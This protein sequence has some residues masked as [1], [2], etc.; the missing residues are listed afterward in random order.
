MET[1]KITDNLIT[2]EG[3]DTYK[4][5]NELEKCIIMALLKLSILP[6][7]IPMESIYKHFGGYTLRGVPD[8][9]TVLPDGT[10]V[11]FEIKRKNVSLSSYQKLVHEK[12]RAR[13]QKVFVVRSIEQTL[14]ALSEIKFLVKLKSKVYGNK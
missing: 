13:K 3:D 9:I 8:L 2:I 10:I 7:K 1:V 4:S 11:W 14:D 5:E 6:I 12:L